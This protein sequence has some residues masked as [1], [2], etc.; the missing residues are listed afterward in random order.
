MCALAPGQPGS[1]KPPLAAPP[2]RLKAT[3]LRGSARIPVQYAKMDRGQAKLY[4]FTRFFNSGGKPGF[5]IHA[6][7]IHLAQCHT[8]EG[9]LPLHTCAEFR[10]ILRPQ[11]PDCGFRAYGSCNT[12]QPTP[13]TAAA[14][15][16]RLKFQTGTIVY[17]RSCSRSRCIGL[18][19]SSRSRYI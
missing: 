3:G 17:S 18:S 6:R 1:R 8:R 14:A 16:C 11:L 2:A 5:A 15:A 12:V 10:D 13:A 9:I 4:R 19:R 7:A